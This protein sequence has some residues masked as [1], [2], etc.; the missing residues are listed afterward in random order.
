[1]K[2]TM[3]KG[4]AVEEDKQWFIGH[5]RHI[6]IPPICIWQSIVLISRIYDVNLGGN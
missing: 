4:I 1:M 3:D 6:I 5:L 2:S